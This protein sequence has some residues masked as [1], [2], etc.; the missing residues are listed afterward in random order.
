MIQMT[1]NDTGPSLVFTIK[2]AGTVVNLTGATVRVTGRKGGATSNKFQ[3]NATLSGTPTDGQCTF[4]WIAADLD[5]T[6]MLALEIQITHSGG[7][8][9]TA[10]SPIQIKVGDEY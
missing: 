9:E 4:A 2:R 7:A 3:R 10:P 6:G 8:I 1:K 5:F